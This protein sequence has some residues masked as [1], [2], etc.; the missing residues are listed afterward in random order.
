MSFYIP[1]QKVENHQNSDANIARNDE[2]DEKSEFL[3]VTSKSNSTRNSTIMLVAFFVIA[4]ISI[5][6]GIKKT[7]PNSAAAAVDSE[8]LLM[9]AAITKITGIKTT[10]TDQMDQIV[11]KFYEFSDVKQVQVDELA[12]NPFVRQTALGST[13]NNDQF[14]I[15]GTLE[16]QQLKQ[17]A[18]SMQLLSIMLSTNSPNQSCCMIDDK[19]LYVGESIK[20]FKI[21]HI[22]ENSVKLQSGTLEIEL[23]LK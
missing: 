17:I 4:L 9:E 11:N 18:N 15:S 22:D 21:S 6:I 16:Q 7:A 1:E 13:A 3:T 20:G 12:K 2:K 23:K 8:D 14:D 19:I 10:M 5:F